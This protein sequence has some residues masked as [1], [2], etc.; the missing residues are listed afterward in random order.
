[1]KRLLFILFILTYSYLFAQYEDVGE[2]GKYF[3]KKNYVEVEIPLF[4]IHKAKLPEPVIEDNPEYL[5]LYWKC[6][7]IAFS[8]FKQ[9]PEDSPFVSNYI[10]EG[11]S[12]SVFQWD[13]AFMMMFMRYASH[14]FPSIESF[15][16]FY[17]RQY[18][19]GYICR[20]IW[21]A[22]GNDF[23]YLDRMH[24]INPP[25]FAWAEI[26]YARISGDQSRIKNI[27]PALEKYAEWLEK[28]RKKE[29]TKHNLYWNTGLG[30][31]MDNSPRKGSA[32]TDMSTQMY[33]FYYSLAE[34][35]EEAGDKQKSE[36]H[37]N[38][39]V[40]I[41]KK[42]NELM[43]NEKDGL[44]YDL[45]DKGKQIQ[46]KTLACFWPMVARLPNITQ[47]ERLLSHL[48]N[49]NEFWRTIPFPSL[50]ADHS[51]YKPE[52]NYW[53]GGVWAPTNYMAIKGLDK[54]SEGFESSFNF[55]EFAAHASE[56]YLD[57]MYKVFKKTGTIWENYAPDFYMR[58]LPMSQSD[59]VGWSGCGP[60]ALLIENV[61]G[62][63]ADA[64]KKEVK[65][66]INR[67]DKHGIQ[68]LQFGDIK[69]SFICDK[70]IDVN[71]TC[72]IKINS[73]QTFTLYARRNTG[74]LLI[75]T[76]NPGFNQFEVD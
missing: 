75:L 18:E 32:W 13:T 24:T 14:I 25:I 69:A 6:W 5:E 30:S 53:L 67:I 51:E 9:P 11:F 74:K 43:W 35:N 7:E 58:S 61:I 15:D 76:I 17:S 29:K 2:R 20:E 52:G 34:M 28:F 10:D 19:N 63:K 64:L 1:M 26:E 54:Y 21:E 60:I 45:D 12:P 8:H 68:N 49:P 23:V 59:F 33:L 40:E 66:D 46:T 38:K 71:K 73:T 22:D 50:S 36:L 47:A 55:R 57:G 37:R 27:L 56:T 65:W 16:N 41:G 48:K 39:A 44:Y 72:R 4:E 70:R 3:T 31:G 42:I 62:I